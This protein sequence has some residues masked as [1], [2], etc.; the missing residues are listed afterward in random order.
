MPRFV[1]QQCNTCQYTEETEKPLTFFKDELE[2]AV[3]C[4]RCPDGVMQEVPALFQIQ[5][6]F[7]PAPVPL[8]K[9]LPDGILPDDVRAAFAEEL[10]DPCSCGQHAPAE[11]YEHSQ[12]CHNRL[13]SFIKNQDAHQN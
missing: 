13:H 4:T 5:K 7:K 11:L 12:E 1:Q 8:K 3:C 2:E 6:P 10:F 9:L